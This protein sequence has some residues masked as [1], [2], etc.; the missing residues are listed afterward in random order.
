MT[1]Q[2]AAWLV[3]LAVGC[4]VITGVGDL[5]VSVGCGPDAGDACDPGTGVTMEKMPL[6]PPPISGS[7]GA[8]FGS[9]DAGTSSGGGDCSSG[10]DIPEI[11]SPMGVIGV[12]P[13]GLCGSGGVPIGGA[14]SGGS[15]TGGKD[16]PGAGGADDGPPPST[17]CAPGSVQPCAGTGSCPGSQMCVADGSGYSPCACA[18]L[19]VAVGGSVAAACASDADCAEGLTC[20]TSAD[21]G[22][23]F[24]NGARPGGPQNGYCSRSCNTDAECQAAD[25][26]AICLGP[27]NGLNHCFASCDA[28]VASFP[29]QCNGRDDLTCI[30]LSLDSPRAYCAPAC[31]DDAGCAPRFCNLSTGLCQ[32]E[33]RTGKPIGAGCS[34][35][36]ECAAGVCFALRG[37]P[38]VC[39][40]LCTFE[41]PAGCGFAADATERD[42]ACVD[43]AFDDGTGPGLCTELC[44]SDSDCEQQ[45]AG[46]T[47]TP[48]SIDVLLVYAQ[49]FE[50]IGFC[51]LAPDVGGTGGGGETGKCTE[52]CLFA[53]D[54]DCDDGGP[55]SRTN[56]CLLG[57]DCTDCGAR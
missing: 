49:A 20:T 37:Q 17:S 27:G 52:E 5:K 38:S 13:A 32:D 16:D 18:P 50:R 8:G 33:Q 28:T 11:F 9:S 6:E 42:A 35:G 36:D 43:T 47:C 7:G 45:A 29:A 56:I 31:Q 48:W 34:S 55:G 46:W 30:P 41:S 26:G 25:P 4:N 15:E 24:S 22:G 21:I 53:G 23:P 1:G 10:R 39:T 19:T 40:G 3:L 57:T 51:E 12:N 44:N 14:G 54:G 2:V